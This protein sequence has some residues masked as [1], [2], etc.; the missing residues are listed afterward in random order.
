[1]KKP[2]ARIEEWQNIGGVYLVGK[3]KDHPRQSEF[4]EDWQ[5]TSPIVK[6]DEE[7]RFC[8]TRNTIYYLGRKYEPEMEVA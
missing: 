5:F 1:M 2:T 7:S 3:V 8:E 6:F 4:K